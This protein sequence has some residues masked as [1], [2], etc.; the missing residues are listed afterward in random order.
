MT[1]T[2]LVVLVSLLAPLRLAAQD[3]ALTLPQAL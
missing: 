3:R 2:L 1:R